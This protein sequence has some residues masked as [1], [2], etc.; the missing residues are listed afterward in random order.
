MAQYDKFV[1]EKTAVGRVTLLP[2]KGKNTRCELLNST[3]KT[4][5]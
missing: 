1:H 5:L 3:M 4:V 2:E